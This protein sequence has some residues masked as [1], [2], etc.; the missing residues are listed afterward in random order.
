MPNAKMEALE[1]APPTKAFNKPSMP[2][3]VLAVRLSNLLGSIPG[4]TIKDPNL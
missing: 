1:K 3:C 4:K 2:P